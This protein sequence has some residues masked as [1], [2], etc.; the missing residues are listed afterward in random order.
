MTQEFL[1]ASLKQDRTHLVRILGVTIPDDWPDE[2]RWAR[3]RLDQL[4]ADP[5][6]QAWLLRAIVLRDED[7]MIGH[8]GFH[9]R[10]GEDYLKELAPGG[11]ELGYTV[12]ERDRRRGYAREACEALMDWAHRSHGVNRFVV[13]ISPGNIASLE[14]AKRLGFNR[15]GSHVDEEDGPEDIFE[16]RMPPSLPPGDS[17]AGH[18]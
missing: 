9:A 11:I 7:R 17:S 6:L 15:I 5:E 3:L 16:L 1:A 4:R 2:P 18:E 14:L 8:V 13:S 12:F 10:P